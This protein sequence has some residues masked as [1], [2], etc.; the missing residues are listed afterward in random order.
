MGNSLKIG[1]LASLVLLVVAVSAPANATLLTFS[2]FPVGTVIT[3]QYA[4]EGVEFSPLTGNAPIIAD[5]GAM[6]TSPVLSPNPP[7]AGDFQ[8]A[9]P[10]GATGVQ[11]DSGFWDTLGTG[12]IQVFDPANVLLA[13]LTDTTLGVDHIDLSGL[14]DIGH[15]TFN[16]VADPAGADIDNLQFAVVPEP[17][18]LLLLGTGL[19]GLG[20]M[21]WRKAM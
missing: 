11:F 17:A 5:D 14:G 1:L 8:F 20:L 15:V 9:F 3:N 18:T 7:F 19:F 16:S 4:P 10:G 2:E 12:L 6:P 13:T 21:R